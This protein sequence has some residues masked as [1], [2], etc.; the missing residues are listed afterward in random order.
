MCSFF[1][2]ATAVAEAGGVTGS[3]DKLNVPDAA[4][5]GEGFCMP[6]SMG[7]SS[8]SAMQAAGLVRWQDKCLVL[9]KR[10]MV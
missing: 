10:A 1:L 4:C 3:A 7:R 6:V 5:R 8:S 2:L 9:V